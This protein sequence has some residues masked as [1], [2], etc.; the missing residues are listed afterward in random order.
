VT[1]TFTDAIDR[2]VV[3]QDS[4]EDIGQVK[5]FICDRS[6][7]RVIKL[8]VAGRKRSAEIVDYGDVSSFGPDAVMIRS[9]SCVHPLETERSADQVRGHVEYLGARV[10]SVEG[11]EHGTVTD[12]HFDETNGAVVGIL[13]D[14]VGR[15]AAEEIRSLG[16]Y[17][18]VIAEPKV[19]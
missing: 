2:R 13:G 7:T 3:A 14:V 11:V 8:Q 5:T 12:V 15:V 1:T 6:G 18:V 10:L 17:A 9:A 16:T 4:A 19:S